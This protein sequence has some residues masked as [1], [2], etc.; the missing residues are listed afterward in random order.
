M[1]GAG[2]LGLFPLA[3]AGVEPRRQPSPVPQLEVPPTP[4]QDT[5]AAGG[6]PDGNDDDGGNSSH[7]TKL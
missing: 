3:S 5:P 4:P 2:A 1:P 7:S 6:D